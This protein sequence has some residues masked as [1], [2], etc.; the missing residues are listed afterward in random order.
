MIELIRL[1]ICTPALWPALAQAQGVVVAWGADI[2]QPPRLRWVELARV[3]QRERDLCWGR[4]QLRDPVG[5]RR[6]GVLG[7]G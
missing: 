7:I 4:P 5:E 1:V 6:G 3:G 2:G